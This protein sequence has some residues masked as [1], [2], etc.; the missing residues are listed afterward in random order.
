[1]SINEHNRLWYEWSCVVWR[2]EAAC[3]GTGLRAADD[4][5]QKE[6]EKAAKGE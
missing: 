5:G 3:R 1:M 4:L 6:G 2:V